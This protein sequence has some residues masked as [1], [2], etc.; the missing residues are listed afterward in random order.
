MDR[1]NF[2]LGTGVAISGVVSCSDDDP[3]ANP[4]SP[5]PQPPK[6]PPPLPIPKLGPQPPDGRQVAYA[7][8]GEDLM[9]MQALSMLGI[10]KPR[11]LDI[12]A[13]HPTIGSNTYLAYL[14]GGQGVLVEPNPPMAKMLLE[15]RPRDVVVNAGVGVGEAA[16]AP[17][18]LIRDR[19]QLNT[20]SKPQV[21]RYLAQGRALEN[22]LDMK[23]VSIDSL[24]REHFTKGLDLLSID[25][26]GLDLQILESMTAEHIR[27]TVV[28][29]ET[30][31][32][33]STA[34]VRPAIE[35]L[36]SR[37]YAVRGGSMIN[38][39]FVDERALQAKAPEGAAL[40]L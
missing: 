3:G 37:G 40:S 11:Y 4:S 17:Y 16:S 8:Q 39:M 34:L 30:A 2:L 23:L 38:T 10:T 25:V 27:A 31:V 28:C 32:F 20:F 15:V 6:N 14:A 36:R 1:R 24:L 12:G 5:A 22:T 19:P 9:L 35:L 18:Y 26:E 33:D 13:F 29:V 7:Q 21:D